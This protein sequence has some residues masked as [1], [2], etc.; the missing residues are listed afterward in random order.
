MQ[1]SRSIIRV[2]HI[3]AA[4]KHRRIDVFKAGSSVVYCNRL[5][6][7]LR[8]RAVG[9]GLQIYLSIWTHAGILAIGSTELINI[10]GSFCFTKH[11]LYVPNGF[12]AANIIKFIFTHK[13]ACILPHEDFGSQL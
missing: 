3:K 4:L 7:A 12:L 2:N 9:E 6:Y 5:V 1:Y 11:L 13:I 8:E 10:D